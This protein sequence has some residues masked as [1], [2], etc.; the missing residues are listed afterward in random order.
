[1]QRLGAE[2][3]RVLCKRT[4]QNSLALMGQRVRK[5]VKS[6]N[7]DEFYKY[8]MKL[9]TE[10]IGKIIRILISLALGFL[11][12]VPGALDPAALLLVFSLC[13][14]AFY[15]LSQRSSLLI[16]SSYGLIVI[17]FVLY[18][19]LANSL[20][21]LMDSR[22]ISVISRGL[23][24]FVFFLTFIL[25][26]S[27]NTFDKKSAYDSVWLSAVFWLL[28]ILIFHFV[29]ILRVLSGELERLSYVVTDVLIPFGV[30][31][32]VLT[33]YKRDL[34]LYCKGALILL[35]GGLVFVSGYRSQVLMLAAVVLF[36]YRVWKRVTGFVFV[37]IMFFCLGVL[38]QLGF[39]VVETLVNRMS[40]S[41]GDEVR[42][43]ELLFAFSQFFD[44]PIFGKGLAV[45]VPVELTR[46]ESYV[47]NFKSPFV[48][49]IHNVIGYFLMNA[50]VV[51][52]VGILLILCIPIAK[53][54]EAWLGG[55]RSYNEGV[56][57]TLCLL[58]VFFMVSAS[59]R[60][61]QMIVVISMLVC[62]VLKKDVMMSS[63][64]R[65]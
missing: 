15:V 3:K 24:P 8:F 33:L 37:L 32:F 29:D 45:Q 42:K 30:I 60:Q 34:S 47:G 7:R 51:G 48:P 41:A 4:D 16:I 63:N 22:E 13:L 38:Y 54:V 2:L 14:Y 43:A 64:R 27:D 1:M 58:F 10:R 23:V 21:A 44:S 19:V 39:P 56:L 36:H 57:I 53:S 50:G 49:Y 35:F 12:F 9:K 18:L 6:L 52:A 5:K 55:A 11:S 59:F 25:F 17:A 46:P 40:G 31:G 61:I 28:N 65:R 62:F 26:W 20:I